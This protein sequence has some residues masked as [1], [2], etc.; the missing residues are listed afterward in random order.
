[1]TN[2]L[3][4]TL[5]NSKNE[6]TFSDPEVI[7]NSSNGQSYSETIHGKSVTTLC[8]RDI[9]GAVALD[10]LSSEK[11][12]GLPPVTKDVDAPDGGYGW[13]VAFGAFL[14]QLTSFG[15]ATSW[16]TYYFF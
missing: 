7:S 8:E 6:K 15:T 14:V 9:N 11:E 12:V 16:G 13:L 4:I 1:M 10:E 3:A 5:D 2:E